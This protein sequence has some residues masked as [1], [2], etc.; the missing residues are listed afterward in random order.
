MQTLRVTPGAQHQRHHRQ[1]QQSEHL[2]PNNING[3][4]QTMVREGREKANRSRSPINN[5]HH[6]PSSSSSTNNNA[7]QNNSLAEQFERSPSQPP[8]RNSSLASLLDNGTTEF[9]TTT[10]NTTLRPVI[11]PTG[12]HSAATQ[13]HATD[14]MAIQNDYLERENAIQVVN[15]TV[16]V[17][18]QQ[19]HHQSIVEPNRNFTI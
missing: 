3:G 18:Q 16:A 2:S 15:A 17:D 12:S 13:S 19:D 10:N 6:H 4:N 8:H 9:I 11:N 14:T 5:S 7:H 1:H